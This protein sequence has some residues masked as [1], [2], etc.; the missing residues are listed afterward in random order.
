MTG[1]VVE[2]KSRTTLASVPAG[3]SALMPP[4]SQGT[5]QRNGRRRRW[6]LR[7]LVVG[8]LA[9]AA[10]LLTGAAAQAADHDAT[11][12]RSSLIGSVVPGD[13]APVVGDVLTVA[14]QPLDDAL[15]KH[16]KGRT[17]DRRKTG[18]HTALAAVDGAVQELT[19]PL[20]LTGGPDDSSRLAPV[21][22]PLTRTLRTVTGTPASVKTPQADQPQA[23]KPQVEKPASTRS[24]A[25]AETPVIRAVAATRTA[26]IVPAPRAAAPGIPAGQPYAQ[27]DA[28]SVGKRHSTVIEGHPAARTAARPDTVSGRTPGG[29]GPAPL[30]VQLGALSGI[31]TSASGAPT[32]GG[33]AAV[34]PAA[35]ANDPVDTHRLRPA[36]DVEA[37]RF[38]A[39]APTVSPD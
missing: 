13:A 2:R 12:E 9:G 36:T 32:E 26:D 21:A 24:P 37:R 30:Q 38:D 20:R 27:P 16:D 22:A 34:L 10:W 28:T 23:A 3:V 33:S 29:D 11:P 15:G 35:V 31:S 39:E 6:A 18:A 17:D 25:S 14:T 8:G 1:W 5:E 7:T 19:G 4:S